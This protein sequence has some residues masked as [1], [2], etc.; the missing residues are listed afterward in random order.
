MT[1]ATRV[2][3]KLNKLSEQQ[4]REVLAFIE[5]LP[6]VPKKPLI[7]PYGMLAGYDTTEEEIAE[8]RREMWGIFPRGDF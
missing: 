1:T 5:K 2:Y 6:P 8:A 7:D 4:Q 3:L